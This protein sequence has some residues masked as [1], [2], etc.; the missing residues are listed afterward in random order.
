M[1]IKIDS[2]KTLFFENDLPVIGEADIYLKDD[3]IAAVCRKF[4]DCASEGKSSKTACTSEDLKPDRIISGKDKLAIPGLI[5]SHTHAYMTMF[6]NIA[7]DVPFT[8]WL[9]DTISP[10]E[11]AMTEQESYFGALLANLEMIRSGTTSYVD[12]HMTPDESA[13]A[14]FDSGMRV[15][16][17]RGLVGDKSDDEGGLR[18][19]KEALSDNE[20]WCDGD[21]LM[22]MLAPHAPYSCGP[23]YLKYIAGYAKEN[24]FGLHI[25]LA[26]GLNEIESI[27]EKYGVTPIEYADRAGVFDVRTIAAHCVHLKDSDFDILREKNVNV[28][29]NPVSNMKLA[30]GFSNVPRMLKEGISVCIGT[31]GAASNNSLNLFREMTIEALIHK[32]LNKDAVTVSAAD[33]LK[34]ATIGGA[35]ALGRES[36]LG[37]IEEGY[38]ADITIIDLKTPAFTPANNLVSALIYSGTGNE[39]D[40]VIVNGKILMEHKE[41]K[42]IDEEKLYYEMDRIGSRYMKLISE[43]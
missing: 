17:T 12:M 38:K 28:A 13:K 22:T 31:D 35:K 32:G 30:N 19:L 5:N 3:R 16:L 14:A 37:R 2:I 15:C 24:G 42:T 1:V 34:M 27:R 26:E 9:F 41:V 36:E 7:D 40:T 11:D 21:R 23:D 10:L 8:E 6:R 4:A 18:R 20:K 29:V 43:K 25:H 33:V 39:V